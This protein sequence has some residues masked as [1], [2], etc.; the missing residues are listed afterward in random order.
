MSTAQ[1]CSCIKT[2]D[3]G[4]KERITHDSDRVAVFYH[5]SLM[6]IVITF[7]ASVKPYEPWN[8]G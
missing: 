2:K 1:Q 4:K 6:P 3:Y 5:D 7:A 8:K